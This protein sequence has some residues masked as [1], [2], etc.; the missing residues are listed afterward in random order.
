M[1][2]AAPK[3]QIKHPINGTYAYGG[4]STNDDGITGGPA[5]DVVPLSQI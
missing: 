5:G 3:K 1:G 4:A 2:D